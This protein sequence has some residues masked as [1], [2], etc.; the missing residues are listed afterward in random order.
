MRAVFV[1]KDYCVPPGA[2]R[3]WLALDLIAPN[4]N[5][6]ARF[7][8]AVAMEAFWPLFDGE[9]EDPYDIPP[10]VLVDPA[11]NLW[12]EQFFYTR[13]FVMRALY[14]VDPNLTIDLLIASATEGRVDSK[15]G[16]IRMT[17]NTVLVHTD[18]LEDL[19]NG[20]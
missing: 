10:W 12:R 20:R 8:C 18:V 13:E 15:T 5:P 9:V 3:W 16:A 1:N 2:L 6:D 4:S 7:D 14:R 11:L 17:A 19:T